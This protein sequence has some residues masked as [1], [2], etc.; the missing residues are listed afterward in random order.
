MA[1][2]LHNSLPSKRRFYRPREAGGYS[3][4]YGHTWRLR[5]YIGDG[6]CASYLRIPFNGPLPYEFWHTHNFGTFPYT[7]RLDGAAAARGSIRGSFVERSVLTRS[8][9]SQVRHLWRVSARAS[10]VGKVR[11]AAVPRRQIAIPQEKAWVFRI[12]FNLHSHRSQP[13]CWIEAKFD[14]FDGCIDH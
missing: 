1:S 13:F 6:L 9:H 2:D 7:W 4:F 11:E 8:G 12:A 3:Q 10:G 5:S 14:A